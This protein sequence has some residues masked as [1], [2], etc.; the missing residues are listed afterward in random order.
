VESRK[1]EVVAPAEPNLVVRCACFRSK[2]SGESRACR[3]MPV[4]LSIPV[5]LSMPVML[6]IPVMSSLSIP[7]MLSEAKHLLKYLLALLAS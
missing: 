2:S 3:S 4:M 6:S 5:M 7:V 1:S